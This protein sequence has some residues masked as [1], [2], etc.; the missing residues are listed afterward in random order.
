MWVVLYNDTIFL[1]CEKLSGG[2]CLIVST[3]I[4]ACV[5][6]NGIGQALPSTEGSEWAGLD[7]TAATSDTE[8]RKEESR[9]CIRRSSH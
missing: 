9:L 7:G 8:V 6:R 4:P 1:V 2:Q 5:E 3:T